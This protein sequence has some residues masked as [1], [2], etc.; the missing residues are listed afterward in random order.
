MSVPAHPIVYTAEAADGGILAR[1]PFDYA[2]VDAIKAA[3]TADTWAAWLDDVG[4]WRV[5]RTLWRRVEQR[6]RAL[7]YS[8]VPL[9]LSEAEEAPND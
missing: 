6:L 8:I 4:A 7:G 1:F 9:G 2:A 5:P 3:R